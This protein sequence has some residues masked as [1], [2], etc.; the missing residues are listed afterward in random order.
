MLEH[1]PYPSC[2]QLA[3]AYLY[4]AHVLWDKYH[5]LF[6]LL[7]LS[8]CHVGYYIEHSLYMIQLCRLITIST[9]SHILLSHYFLVPGTSRPNDPNYTVLSVRRKRPKIYRP[10]HNSTSKLPSH[11]KHGSVPNYPSY[12]LRCSTLIRVVP[13]VIQESTVSHIINI[14]VQLRYQLLS[15]QHKPL[16]Q[17]WYSQI[18]GNATKLYDFNSNIHE[19]QIV[20]YIINLAERC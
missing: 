18:E 10:L 12:S 4:I 13:T 16:L 9:D 3:M 7:N 15:F 14:W 8:L 19:R 20:V 2:P 1:D 5:L 6:S 17:C 11:L